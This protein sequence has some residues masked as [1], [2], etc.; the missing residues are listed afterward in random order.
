MRKGPER[1]RLFRQL[2]SKTCERLLHDW[3]VWGRVD[4]QWEPD[5]RMTVVTAGRGWGKTHFAAEQCHRMADEWIDVCGGEIGIAGRTH[6]DTM[7]AIIHGPSGIIAT[8]KPWNQCTVT[9]KTVK[10]R[11]GAV[12]H[13]MTGD[14]PEGFRSYNLGFL[15]CD[16]FAHWKY[17][18]KCYQAFEFGVR[19]G[20]RPTIIIT[21]T[22]LPHPIF[23]A[24]VADPLTKRIRGRTMDNLLNIDA[25][26]LRGWVSR[27]G[28]TELGKQ[29]LEGE[30][31][32]GSKHAP[33]RQQD[34]RRIESHECPTLFRTVVAIDPSGGRHKKSDKTGIVCAAIDDDANTY[35]LDDATDR[36]APED[37]AAKAIFMARYHGADAIVG[38]RNYGGDMVLAVIRLHPDWPAAQADGIRLIDVVSVESK[39]HRALAPAMLYRQGKAFHVGD[40][41][42]YALLE[43]EMTHYD[44]TLPRARQAS[45]DAM[46]A[47]VHAM[48]ELHPDREGLGG[49]SAY[50]DGATEDFAKMLASLGGH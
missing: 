44:P 21:S 1:E 19:R 31:L 9:G 33:W 37:W 10:W 2:G 30:I 3:R 11:S 24:I 4:Q 13:I 45:P 7:A 48:A 42:K 32:D 46:D 8:Q 20:T 38:E 36:Y 47:L 6:D 12:G 43:Y 49:S 25:D 15:W 5:T 29:E 41:H 22:P 27:Y 17:L 28:G 34:I 50:D 14:R 23:K 26:T 40:P 18:E 35:V 16:E 39:G